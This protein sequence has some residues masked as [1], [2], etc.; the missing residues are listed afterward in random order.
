MKKVFK[1]IKV[2]VI[3]PVL[4][5]H[6]TVIRQIRHFKRMRLPDTVEFIFVDDGS[7]PPIKFNTGLRNLHFLYTNDT[8]AWTQG[9]ARNIGARFALGEYLF[10]TD[11]D[12]VISK[13]A[14]QAALEFTGDKMVFRREY[15]YLD[16]YGNV[17]QD[18]KVLYA[19]GLDPVRYKSRGLNAGFHPTTFCIRKSIFEAM[20]GFDINFCQYGF[21]AGKKFM[22]EDRDFYL[23]WNRRVNRGV[24]QAEVEGP[25][26]Y[27]FPVGRF[28]IKNDHNPGGLFHNLSLEQPT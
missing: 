25:K 3:I 27:M 19:R 22:S 20:D 21:H 10:F 17:T 8:R 26:I 11:V 9:I 6:K 18:L 13:E 5:S 1:K 16:A 15:G 23:R 14:M 28:H 12:H 7:D 2:S 4:N 24:Y